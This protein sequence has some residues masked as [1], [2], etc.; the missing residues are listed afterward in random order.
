MVQRILGGTTTQGLSFNDLDSQQSIILSYA[1]TFGTLGALLLTF[2]MVQ[3]FF[4]VNKR[5]ASKSKVYSEEI[6]KEERVETAGE[7]H[8]SPEIPKLQIENIGNESKSMD[9][10]AQASSSPVISSKKQ[11]RKVIFNADGS[12]SHSRS[13]IRHS[14]RDDN[15]PLEPRIDDEEIDSP[16]G[17]PSQV[18]LPPLDVSRP[19]RKMKISMKNG[20]MNYELKNG[21]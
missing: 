13:I 14:R 16:R 7:G 15:E 3:L 21:L 10:Q 6:T 18:I 5:M 19:K 8:Y 12:L 11:K 1:Y 2:L 20:Q 9:E 17:A 4:L